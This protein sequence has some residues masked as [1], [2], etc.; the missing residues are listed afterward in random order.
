MEVHPVP[1]NHQSI[2]ES[3]HVET[4]GKVLGA[5]LAQAADGATEFGDAEVLWGGGAREDD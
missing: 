5:C 3:P 1:G 2:V 4:L